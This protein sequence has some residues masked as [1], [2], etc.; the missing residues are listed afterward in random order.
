VK[1]TTEFV[2][3]G[4]R[5]AVAPTRPIRRP[6]L[7]TRTYR[8]EAEGT[9]WLRNRRYVF[10]MVRE[11]TSIPIAAWVVVFMVQVARLQSG[12]AGYQPFG[13]PLWIAFSLVCLVAALWHSFTFLSLAG[14]II[15]IPR[16]EGF[17]HPRFIVGGMFSLLVAAT[18]VVGGLLVLG[19]S[20]K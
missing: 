10:Y 9:W 16:R 3:W 12:R 7:S 11:F 14:R 13:G 15:R 18:I 4:A 2:E 8:P 20:T 19:G 17:V 1:E 5:G 6:P